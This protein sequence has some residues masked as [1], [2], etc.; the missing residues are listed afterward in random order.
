MSVDMALA[1]SLLAAL[2]PASGDLKKCIQPGRRLTRSTTVDG[3]YGPIESVKS[4]I[5]D[6]TASRS[7]YCSAGMPERERARARERER[8]KERERKPDRA[9]QRAREIESGSETETVGQP[10]SE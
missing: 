9:R 5:F 4:N 8:E 2:A 10:A 3:S 1:C 7:R 6:I